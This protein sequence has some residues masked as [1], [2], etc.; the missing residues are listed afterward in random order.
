[1]RNRTQIYPTKLSVGASTVSGGVAVITLK[2][3]PLFQ[4]ATT[5]PTGTL[6][7]TSANL[8]QNGSNP[9]LLQDVDIVGT[10]LSTF[11][12][13]YGWFRCRPVINNVVNDTVIPISV[14]GVLELDTDGYK[15]TSVN[16]LDGDWAIMPNQAFLIERNYDAKASPNLNN[17][18]PTTSLTRLSAILVDSEQRCPIPG[19][20]QS[21]STQYAPTGGT[22]FDLTT[23]FDYNKDYLSFPLTNQ[24]ESVYVLASSAQALGS[25]TVS[26]QLTASLTWEEQ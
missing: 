9:V 14:L 16:T 10:Y 6:T 2:K 24:V 8:I 20:G 11:D 15:F 7:V 5:L 18:Y 21:V 22:E 4:T 19:T 1:V 12:R 26:A 23:Y 3:T 13:I 17:S 25:P